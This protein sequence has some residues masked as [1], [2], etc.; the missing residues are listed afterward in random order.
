M[1]RHDGFAKTA[2]EVEGRNTVLSSYTAWSA[3]H[4]DTGHELHALDAIVQDEHAL[5]LPLRGMKALNMRFKF[6]PPQETHTNVFSCLS[7]SETLHSI[8]VTAPQS[9]HWYS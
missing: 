1:Q 5:E 4:F 8:S 6:L 7:L 2:I 3:V 9:M